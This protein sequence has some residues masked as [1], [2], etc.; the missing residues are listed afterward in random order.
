M[1]IGLALV[2]GILYWFATNKLWYGTLH[3]IR[4]PIVL[5]VPIGLIMG[6]LPN[7]MIIGASLQMIY[8]GAIAPGGTLPSD[9]AL[10]ACIAIPLALEANLEPGI[11]VTLA[12]PIGLLG[13]LIDNLKRTYHSYFIHLADKAVEENNLKK[14]RR[15]EFWYPLIVSVPLR[16]VPAALALAFG[17][18]AVTAFLNSIPAWATNG[19]SVAGGLLPALGFAVTIMVIGKKKLLP[20]FI[21]G[22]AI[23]AYSGINTI[24]VAV[25]AIC[26]ALLQGNFVQSDETDRALSFADGEE[27]DF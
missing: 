8:L 7:A 2:F 1:S 10:A 19:L 21:I 24:G 16:V 26:I 3:L 13:V 23:V 12:V 6:D 17:V 11:A 27:G 20:Y 18:D 5:A 14:M 25:F 22:F 9:E 4:Q 15:A